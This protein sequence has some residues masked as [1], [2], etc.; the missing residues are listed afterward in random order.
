[1]EN[2][3]QPTNLS[4]NSNNPDISVMKVCITSSGKEPL[5]AEVIAEDKGNIERLIEESSYKYQLYPL[6]N[7]KRL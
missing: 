7:E 5:L 2:Y 1:M 4:R 6:T 3:N